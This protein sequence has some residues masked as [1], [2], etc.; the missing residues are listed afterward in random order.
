VVEISVVGVMG[1]AYWCNIHGKVSIY[2]AVD[3]RTILLWHGKVSV[4][5]PVKRQEYF[6]QSPYTGSAS[7]H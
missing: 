6:R 5:V 3:Q 1:E 2:K 7:F 4:K